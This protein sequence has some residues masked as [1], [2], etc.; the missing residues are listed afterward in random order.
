LRAEEI[1]P[2]SGV[3]AMRRALRYRTRMTT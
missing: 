1:G 3:A 2:A